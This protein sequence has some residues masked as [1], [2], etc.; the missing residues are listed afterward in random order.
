M[1]ISI[2]GAISVITAGASEI[3]G[4]IAELF[5]ESGANVFISD[6]DEKMLSNFGGQ[7]NRFRKESR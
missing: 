6:I 5:V 7:P 1:N 4:K 3:C 2:D